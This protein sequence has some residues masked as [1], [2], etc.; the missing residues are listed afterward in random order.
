MFSYFKSNLLSIF[1][2]SARVKLLI[3]L[4][5]LFSCSIVKNKKLYLIHLGLNHWSIHLEVI[6]LLHLQAFVLF[7]LSL[8]SYCI[9]IF[10][11]WFSHWILTSD[12]MFLSFLIQ[13]M[14][15]YALN[16]KIEIMR[17]LTDFFLN[18]IL[19]LMSL[20]QNVKIGFLISPHDLF[21][22]LSTSYS[23]RD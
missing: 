16:C 8:V 4:R 10:R 15:H 11:S 18:F 17:N 1:S 21:Q 13:V 9:I 7:L 23:R 5:K 19:Q 3:F 6:K 22:M 20:I 14:T 2:G 12:L